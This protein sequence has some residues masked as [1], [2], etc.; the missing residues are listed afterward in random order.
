MVTPFTPQICLTFLVMSWFGARLIRRLAMPVAGPRVCRLLLVS[1]GLRVV[2]AV[3]FFAISYWRLPV[4]HPLQAEI[5]GFWQFAPDASVYHLC[6]SPLVSVW[7]AGTP[8]PYITGL[9]VEYLVVV[10]TIYTFFGSHPLLA[11]VVN[12]FL[13]TLSGLL[14]FAISRRLSGE[15]PAVV[16]GLFVSFWPSTLIWSSQLLKDSLSLF[17][18]LAVLL[19]VLQAC[20][21][22]RDRRRIGILRL[23]A[24]CLALMSSVVLLTRLRFYLGSILAL[25]MLVV[26]LPAAA[27]AVAKRRLSLG[28]EY[29][30]LATMVVVSVLFA[31]GLDTAHLLSSIHPT[32]RH[33]QL[34]MRAWKA[35]EFAGAAEEFRQTL[36]QDAS[37]G[38]A[39]FALAAVHIQE[40]HFDEAARVYQEYLAQVPDDARRQAEVRHLAGQLHVARGDVALEENHF[41]EAQ[42]AYEEALALGAAAS[43]LYEHLALALEG[44]GQVEDAVARAQQAL[45]AA[46][47]PQETNRVQQM[48]GRL[49]AAQGDH[50]LEHRQFVEAQRAF[51]QALRWVAPTAFL[52]ERLALALEGQGQVE[53]AIA[54]VKEALVMAGGNS[55]AVERVRHTLVTLLVAHTKKLLDAGQWEEAQTVYEEALVVGASANPLDAYLTVARGGERTPELATVMPEETLPMAPGRLPEGAG[56]PAELSLR[57]LPEITVAAPHVTALVSEASDERLQDLALLLMS[58]SDASIPGGAG[59]NTVVMDSFR[60]LDE[61]A[62]STVQEVTPAALGGWRGGFVTTGG[63]SLM[64]P[65]AVISR[66]ISLLQYLP[67]ALAIGLLAPFPWQWFDTHGSTGIMRMF[68]GLEMLLLY[69]M[70]PVMW[71]GARRFVASRRVEAY[72][73]LVWILLVAVPL[74]LVV[75]NMGTLFRLRLAFVLP[76]LIVAAEGKPHEMWSRMIARLGRFRAVRAGHDSHPLPREHVEATAS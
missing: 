49:S 68:S 24:W 32:P 33:F 53:A 47:T 25:T 40:K 10:A 70:L 20:G 6:G 54:R 66:L 14:A 26:F 45:E 13:G 18:T 7:L 44:Q 27:S 21:A 61:Q 9:G 15:R 29:L 64:D 1:Y 56:A 71:V 5:P 16:S 46:A 23:I 58:Q 50:L 28:A 62:V 34:G 4:L 30:V 52:Y 59:R 12:C 69:L 31:R 3:V 11:V 74:S 41:I 57:P 37:N 72:V 55:E 60:Q 43:A 22:V 38:N 76:L 63:H 65:H 48:L 51:E 39:Y 19:L 75:A 35:G 36:A 42:A 73:L 2:L 17:L 67:R 8:M